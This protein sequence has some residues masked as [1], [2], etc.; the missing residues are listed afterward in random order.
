MAD[1]PALQ[2]YVDEVYTCNRTRCGF[3]SVECPVFRVKHI[4]T[5][6]SR[7]RMLAIRG[8]LEGILEPSADLQ[9]V[10]DSCL[11]CGYCQAR[12]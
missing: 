9:E 5:Y 10:L 1:Y 12:C 3:C 2:P 11:M 4:E 7:G 8:L 6:A